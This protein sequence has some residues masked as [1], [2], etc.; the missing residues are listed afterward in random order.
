MPRQPR[1]PVRWGFVLASGLV[2]LAVIG[3][4]V[5][6]G[7]AVVSANPEFQ[8]NAIAFVKRTLSP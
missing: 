1:V 2:M 3:A 7:S 8:K 4:A 6:F 5:H